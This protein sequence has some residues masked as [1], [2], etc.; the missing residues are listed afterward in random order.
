MVETFRRDGAD[1]DRDTRVMLVVGPPGAGKSTYV[2]DHAADGDLIVDYDVIAQAFGVR[3]SHSVHLSQ[4]ATVARN[5][6]LDQLRRGRLD[7]ATAWVVSANP[8]AETLFV[9]DE[10]VVVDPGRD[11]VL[12]RCRAAG[13][14]SRWFPLVD[15]W[16]RKRG[17]G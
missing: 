2:A 17:A 16:Y 6:V 13:R 11:E 15:D 10:V 8:A 1:V 12:R 9:Y 14:P 5:A 7:V 3:E 4:A